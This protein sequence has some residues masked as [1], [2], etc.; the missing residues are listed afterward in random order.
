MTS[1]M[2]QRDKA[3][4]LRVSDYSET[5]QVLRFLTR[6]YGA[7]RLL[8]KGAKRPK[9]K[10]GG[11]L[12]LLSEGDVIFAPPRGDG[13]GTLME[14]T[15]TTCQ[16]ALRLDADKL[17]TALYMVELAGEMLADQDPHPEVF[18]LLHNSLVRLG[19]PDAPARAVLAFY[20]S[21]LLAHVGLIGDLSRCVSCRRQLVGTGLGRREAC[22]SAGEGGL[23][24]RDCE[25]GFAEKLILGPAALAGLAALQAAG[26]KRQG[27]RVSLADDQ[28]DAVNRMFAYYVA[29]MLGKPLKMARHV[30]GKSG[31]A[32]QGGGAIR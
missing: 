22:F 26:E 4:C 25:A 7:V 31:K 13:L 6:G 20:Q 29:N 30:I 9:S 21:R 28:A 3:I 15:E 23:L 5:S 8:A 19:Q 24:C 16:P 10:S 11:A 1:A 17:Y 12:D 27:R 14:F 32:R 18:D 2:S